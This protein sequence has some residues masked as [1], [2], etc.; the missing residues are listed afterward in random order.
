MKIQKGQNAALVR[1]SS[2]AVRSWRNT[3]RAAAE[4]QDQNNSSVPFA[5]SRTGWGLTWRD[6]SI[7]NTEANEN[8]SAPSARNLLL[9][10]R[11]LEFMSKEFTRKATRSILAHCAAKFTPRRL[12]S[13]L[14]SKLFTT[15]SKTSN[16]LCVTS[17]SDTEMFWSTIL[18]EFTKKAGIF[19]AMFATRASMTNMT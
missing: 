13:T 8:L 4:S 6:T 1:L 3:W 16:A 17:C 14:T 9:W 2:A 7:R 11:S 18:V 15:R 19:S 12:T 10:E 5:P